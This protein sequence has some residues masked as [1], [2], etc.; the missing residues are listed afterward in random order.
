MVLFTYSTFPASSMYSG[1]FS[2]KVLAT[3]G[4]THSTPN[5]SRIRLSRPVERALWKQKCTTPLQLIYLFHTWVDVFTTWTSNSVLSFTK[6]SIIVTHK[7]SAPSATLVGSRL[8][9]NLCH[10]RR[11][12]QSSDHTLELS[13]SIVCG[14]CPSYKP[15]KNLL[16]LPHGL[17]NVLQ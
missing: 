17:I 5:S 9:L 7:T 4:C 1:I 16:A 12:P 10:S 2:S 14:Q 15:C 3:E 8:I 13:A 6:V 11:Q